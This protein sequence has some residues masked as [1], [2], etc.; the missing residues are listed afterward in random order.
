MRELNANS[1]GT[2]VDEVQEVMRTAWIPLAPHNGGREKRLVARGV[3]HLEGLEKCRET[4]LSVCWR[5]AARRSRYPS[6]ER[7]SDGG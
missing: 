6:R 7:R 4:L 1:N 3:S 2:L 5:A